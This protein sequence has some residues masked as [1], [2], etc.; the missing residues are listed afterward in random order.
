VKTLVIALSQ[1]R[2]KGKRPVREKIPRGTNEHLN[3]A[4]FFLNEKG[5][6]GIQKRRDH[7]LMT[8]VKNMGR[9]PSLAEGRKKKKKKAGKRRSMG[10]RGEKKGRSPSL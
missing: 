3:V 10:K 9:R 6:G 8:C 5:K 2:G 4:W 7:F 1:E